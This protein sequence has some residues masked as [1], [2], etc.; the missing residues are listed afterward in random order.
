MTEISGKSPNA[1][2]FA[3]YRFL[4][5]A[6]AATESTRKKKKSVQLE[7]PAGLMDSYVR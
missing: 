3:R 1:N 2:T 6:T 5:S 7:A 4:P